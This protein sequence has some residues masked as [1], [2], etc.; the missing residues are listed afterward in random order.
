[1]KMPGKLFDWSSDVIIYSC[2]RGQQF[3]YSYGMEVVED[4]LNYR[5]LRDDGVAT[6]Q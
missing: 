5:R 2:H 4:G 3:S 1:M 6:F